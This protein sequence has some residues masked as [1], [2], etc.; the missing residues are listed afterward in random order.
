MTFTFHSMVTF[1]SAV[2]HFA[3]TF[4][5]LLGSTTTSRFSSYFE[6]SCPEYS[7]YEILGNRFKRKTIYL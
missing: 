2:N 1:A 3:G 6:S 5:V 7:K 4:K